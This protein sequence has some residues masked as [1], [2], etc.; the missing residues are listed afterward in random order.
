MLTQQ[1]KQTNI[2]KD[3]GWANEKLSAGQT[4]SSILGRDAQGRSCKVTFSRPSIRN[5]PEDLEKD[6]ILLESWAFYLRST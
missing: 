4:G 2:C 3:K 1:L 5:W 6:L